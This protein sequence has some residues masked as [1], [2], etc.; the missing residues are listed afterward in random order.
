MGARSRPGLPSCHV[1]LRRLRLDRACATLIVPFCHLDRT[2]RHLDRALCCFD[3]ALRHTDRYDI[4]VA[5]SKVPTQDDDPITPIKMISV[6]IEYPPTFT[7][8]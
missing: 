4:C 8:A 6:T 1:S 5:I 7:P 3:R 2:L